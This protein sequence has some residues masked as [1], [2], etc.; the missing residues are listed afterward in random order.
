ML[1]AIILA[2]EEWDTVENV[3][4]FIAQLPFMVRG[5]LLNNM[6]ENYKKNYY[7][8]MEAVTTFCK[9]RAKWRSQAVLAGLDLSDW[10]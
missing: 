7:N 6:I 8:Q 10:T 2:M 5:V 3:D 4:L 1:P 9:N